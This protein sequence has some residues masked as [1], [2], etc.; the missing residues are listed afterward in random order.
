MTD[1]AVGIGLEPGCNAC[2]VELMGAGELSSEAFREES[3][4]TDGTGQLSAGGVFEEMDWEVD[5]H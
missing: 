1:T 4:E 2:R 5:V 3:V